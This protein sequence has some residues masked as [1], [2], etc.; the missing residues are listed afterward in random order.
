MSEGKSASEVKREKPSRGQA[1]VAG[2][3][4]WQNLTSAM[5]ALAAAA[6]AW[7]YTQKQIEDGAG[8]S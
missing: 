6:W 8:D 3:Q 5:I 1:F 7:Q 4:S 2:L